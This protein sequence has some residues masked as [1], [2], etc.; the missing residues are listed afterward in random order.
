MTVKTWDVFISHAS[1]DKAAV[2]NPLANSLERA[3]LRVWLDRQELRLGDSLREKI[4][5][6]WTD[7]EI[8]DFF[9][10]GY[11]EHVLLDPPLSGWGLALWLLPPVALLIGGW[12]IWTRRTT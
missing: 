5:E 3:G 11:G 1:E 2:T 8:Y 10:S 7:D 4:D 6:G 12:I 9:A